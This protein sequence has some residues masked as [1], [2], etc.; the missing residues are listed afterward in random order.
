[1][2][3]SE[4]LA[5]FS[6]VAIVIASYA[7]FFFLQIITSGSATKSDRQ[8]HWLFFIRKM[9]G[10][11]L[12][13]VIPS[14]ILWLLFEK[15]PFNYGMKLGSTF[16]LWHWIAGASLFF[17]MLNVFNSRSPLLQK[18]YPEMRINTWK[19]P[20][21]ILL[22]GGWILYLIGYEFVFRGLFLFSCYDAF[23][24]W[25]AVVIN[26]SLYSA[27]HLPKGMKEATAAIPF[28]A[29]ICYFTLESQ[30]IIPAIFIHSL[31]A[32]SCEI[33]CIYRNPE[34]KFQFNKSVNHVK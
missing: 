33:L 16:K 22:S 20:G 14:L 19:L 3:P 24:L 11:I 6:T 21:I 26:I 5:V 1:M 28:G 4:S 13:G 27:L 29:L 10:F 25:P 32:I 15:N 18:I 23:G 9:A 17:I 8:L 12:L 34:M 7:Y 2:N 31:Q 30:S